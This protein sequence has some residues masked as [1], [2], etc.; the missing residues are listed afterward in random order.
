MT[1][2]E[3]TAAARRVCEALFQVSEDTF[4]REDARQIDPSKQLEA[5]MRHHDVG[6]SREHLFRGNEK[7]IPHAWRA[8]A[9]LIEDNL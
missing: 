1:P 4:Y 8:I 3:K 7:T 2:D 5:V 9:K 6:A